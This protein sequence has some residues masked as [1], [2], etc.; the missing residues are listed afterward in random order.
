[1]V[2]FLILSTSFAPEPSGI[3]VY[4]S[5]LALYLK[6]LGHDVVVI[7][8]KSSEEVGRVVSFEFSEIHIIRLKSPSSSKFGVVFSMLN[9]I[10]LLFQMKSAIKSLNLGKNTV[11]ISYV[12]SL[13]SGIVSGR[14]AK[15]QGFPLITIFQDL[16][17]MGSRQINS[18]IGRFLYPVILSIEKFIARRSDRIVTVSEE[19]KNAISQFDKSLKTRISLIYN[20]TVEKKAASEEFDFR[21]KMNLKNEDFLVMHTGNMGRKQGLENVLEAAKILELDSRIK[22]VLIGGGNQASSI[23]LKAKTLKNV[24][25]LPFVDED[26]YLDTLK[27]SNLLLVNEIPTQLGMSLPS[28]LTSYLASGVPIIASVPLLGPTSNYLQDKAVI[29]EAGKPE[30]LASGVLDALNNL[31]KIQDL[32]SNGRSFA[33]VQLNA[34]NARQNYLSIIEDLIRQTE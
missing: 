6:S 28:K 26:E 20:Y 8:S 2:N 27:S 21:K 22:F 11:V 13:S 16:S 10:R 5:D 4:S 7:T 31:S 25:V 9:E 14:L 3:A 33:K 12:P 24:F 29:I 32:A 23:L 18:T 15:S 19:M 30:L 34:V 1:M 17:S